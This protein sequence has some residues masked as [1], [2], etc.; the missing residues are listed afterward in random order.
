MVF[1]RRANANEIKMDER[2]REWK[3]N[4]PERFGKKIG[5]EKSQKLT[6]NELD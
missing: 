3:Q 2:G 6:V 5:M 4:E 1:P